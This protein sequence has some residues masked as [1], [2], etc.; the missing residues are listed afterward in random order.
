[1]EEEGRVREAEEVGRLGR[2]RRRG[3]L[4]RQCCHSVGFYPNCL[5]F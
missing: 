5:D 1:M 3:G 4:G 2:W